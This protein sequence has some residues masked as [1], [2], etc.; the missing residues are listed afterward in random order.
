MLFVGMAHAAVELTSDG[1]SRENSDANESRR[2]R[3]PATDITMST[4]TR[5][6]GFRMNE[7]DSAVSRLTEEVCMPQR[8]NS[9]HNFRISIATYSSM[10]GRVGLSR[11]HA[12]PINDPGIFYSKLTFLSSIELG[13]GGKIRFRNQSSSLIPSD[14][15]LWQT[16]TGFLIVHLLLQPATA[17]RRYW[18]TPISDRLRLLCHN[19]PHVQRR[20]DVCTRENRKTSS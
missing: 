15:C 17:L 12:S 1:R 14:G 20:K 10:A 4:A 8:S 16:G 6:K 11:A 9:P 18:L 19:D 13:I 7:M 5:M 2:A 3:L